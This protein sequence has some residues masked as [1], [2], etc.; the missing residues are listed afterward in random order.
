MRVQISSQHKHK[1][2]FETAKMTSESHKNFIITAKH[3]VWLYC[4]NI[5]LYTILYPH[6]W[7]HSY[8]NKI[9][10]LFVLIEDNMA[11]FKENKRE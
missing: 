2:F 3:P 10:E 6:A 8:L 4:I 1:L 9:I 7:L 5:Y 11:C